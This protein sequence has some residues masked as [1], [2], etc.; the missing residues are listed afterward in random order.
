LKEISSSLGTLMYTL[1]D[2]ILHSFKS[3]NYK[4][5]FCHVLSMGQGPCDIPI[6]GLTHSWILRNSRGIWLLN[7]EQK[8]KNRGTQDTMAMEDPEDPAS[9]EVAY[10][11]GGIL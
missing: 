10:K 7:L 6:V 5:W 2:T 3:F 11:Y 8:P 9:L 4:K 1:V